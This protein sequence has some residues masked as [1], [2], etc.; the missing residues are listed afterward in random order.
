MW[1]FL[2]SPIQ[3][4]GPV[5]VCQPRF[6]ESLGL[7]I[8]DSGLAADGFDAHC[9]GQDGLPGEQAGA[10]LGKKNTTIFLLPRSVWAWASDAKNHSENQE[11]PNTFVITSVPCSYIFFFGGIG[12]WQGLNSGFHICKAGTLPLEPHLHSILLWLFWRWESHELFAQSGLK[13]RSSQV[14]RIT[15]VSHWH[16]VLLFHSWRRH[17]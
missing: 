12:E 11:M 5:D 1:V 7:G 10:I 9:L 6:L 2:G 4:W 8:R 16:Q 13:L 15:D 3:P 14:A 17:E